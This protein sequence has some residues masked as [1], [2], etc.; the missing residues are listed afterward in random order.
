M[1]AELLGDV[2]L[3]VSRLSV[4]LAAG[5]LWPSETSNLELPN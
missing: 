5:R 2:V 4:L 1:S 3:C